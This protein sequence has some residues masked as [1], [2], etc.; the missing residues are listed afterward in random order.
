MNRMPKVAV[1][2][3]AMAIHACEPFHLDGEE[4]NCIATRGDAV[5]ETLTEVF[6][7]VCVPLSVDFVDFGLCSGVAHMGAI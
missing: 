2:F 3:M 4:G 5:W 7:R 1:C 6:R